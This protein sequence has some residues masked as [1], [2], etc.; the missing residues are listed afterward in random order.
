MLNGVGGS[1]VEAAKQTITHA[2]SLKWRAYLETRGPA[3]LGLRMEAG[4]AMLAVLINRALGGHLKFQDVAPHFDEPSA[5][6]SDVM[7]IL[8]GTRN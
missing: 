1:S 5:S 2:E 4:F 3:N 7:N 6:I 8:A